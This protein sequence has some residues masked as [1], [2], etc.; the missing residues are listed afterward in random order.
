MLKKT[1]PI[2]LI[3]ILINFSACS[4]SYNKEK[5]VVNGLYEKKVITS[6]LTIE[7]LDNFNNLYSQGSGVVFHK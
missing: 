7:T 4:I 6:N 1:L 3:V 5:D 2:L